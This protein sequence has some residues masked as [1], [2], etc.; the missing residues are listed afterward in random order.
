MSAPNLPALR[1]RL[2]GMVE[3]ARDHGDLDGQVVVDILSSAIVR[4]LVEHESDRRGHLADLL[5]GLSATLLAARVCHMRT[6]LRHVVG[7][8]VVYSGAKVAS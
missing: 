7:L 6:A 5:C 4:K 2:L 1:F 3:S 8:A